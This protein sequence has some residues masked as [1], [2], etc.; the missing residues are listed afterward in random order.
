MNHSFHYDPFQNLQEK[1]MTFED[2]FQ[3]IANFM[4]QNPKG[5]Y[6]LI[7]GTDSQVHKTYT[8]FITGIVILR[9]GDGVWACIRRVI[10]PRKMLH[11]H[12]RISLELS[13]TEE[14]VS[15]F[16]EEK[17]KELIDIVLPSIYDGSTF[18]MEGH[19]DIGAG[20]RNKTR[21]FV[22]EMVTRM[23]SIGVEPKIKPDAFVASS[24]AN[25]FTK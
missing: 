16:T 21:E 23:K 14:V 2:V 7:I 13:F 22:N 17:K 19:I 24:Y 11:L 8:I 4:H 18:A 20:N 1:N 6:R 12:E 15:M 10:V 25:H 9:E 5:Q 3:Y